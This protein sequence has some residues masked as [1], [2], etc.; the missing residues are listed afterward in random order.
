MSILIMTI[1]P[2]FS[3]Q[4]FQSRS[5]FSPKGT[6]FV[7]VNEPAQLLSTINTS[8]LKTCAIKCNENI[9]CR[10]FDYG[11]SA[12]QQCRL[13]E[14]DPYISGSIVLSSSS[15]STVGVVQI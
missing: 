11:V 8:S 5:I 2:T 9:L 7:P 12:L 15:Q 4:P 10:I 13:F 6:Q 3:Q 1:D 14:G